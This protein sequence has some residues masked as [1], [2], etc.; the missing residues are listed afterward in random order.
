MIESSAIF[1]PF[2][3][4]ALIFAV[5]IALSAMSA[6]AILPSIILALFTNGCATPL[7]LG[8]I[9]PNI[10]PSKSNALFLAS[11]PVKLDSVDEL[12]RSVALIAVSYTH[13]TLPTIYS[14]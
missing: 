6:V 5:V 12:L 14:V 3:A 11:C 8:C 9:P 2:T 10:D 7:I 1:V 4:S 13:L